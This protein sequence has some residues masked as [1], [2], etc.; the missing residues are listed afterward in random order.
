MLLSIFRCVLVTYFKISHLFAAVVFVAV[1]AC[2]GCAQEEEVASYAIEGTWGTSQDKYEITSDSFK[3]Y[4]H[5]YIDSNGYNE[6]ATKWFLGLS[7]KN[8]EIDE[9]D[10]TSGIIYGEYDNSG[11]ESL[12][13]NGADGA[14]YAI[15]YFGLKDNAVN[16]SMAG[17]PSDECTSLEKAKDYYTMKNGSFSTEK[18]GYSALKRLD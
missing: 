12:M 5:W 17:N 10:E 18:G 11:K 14:W 3:V 2:T 6:D 4:G 13:M 8:L 9:I 15:Y 16:L 1:L 7:L